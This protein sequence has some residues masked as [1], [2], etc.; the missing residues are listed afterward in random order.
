MGESVKKAKKSIRKA[1]NT[2]NVFI[3]I[4]E[5]SKAGEVLECD[6]S[7]TETEE[8]CILLFQSMAAAANVGAL[9]WVLP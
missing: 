5:T 9:N 3:Q 7:D 8:V 1:L 2:S 6:T 4:R